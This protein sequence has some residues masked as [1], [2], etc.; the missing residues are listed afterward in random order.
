[1]NLKFG[2]VM[3]SF[4]SLLKKHSLFFVLVSAGVLSAVLSC[5][6]DG[7]WDLLAEQILIA[8]ELENWNRRIKI[9]IDNSAQSDTLTDFPVLVKLNSSNIS[10]SDFKS[11]GSDLS[12]YSSALD[13]RLDYETDT[14]DISGDS[15]IWVR[16][17]SI[18][19]GSA[20]GYFWM[21]YSSDVNTGTQSPESVWSDDYRGVWHLDESGTSYYDSS[22]NGNTGTGGTF[23]QTD[24][25]VQ[26][27]AV[28]LAQN[29]SLTTDSIAIPADPS[30]NDLG[31][32]TYSFW[33]YNSGNT[34]DR[35]LSKDKF[36]FWVSSSTYIRVE[37]SYSDGTMQREFNVMPEGSWT[38][39]AITWD[40]T[41]DGSKILVYS[42]GASVSPGS[43]GNTSGT[44]SSDA[45]SDLFI[46]NDTFFSA[47]NGKNCILDEFR[48]SGKV[49][50]A[51]WIAAQ[52]LSQSGSFLSYGASETVSH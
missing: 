24:P 29:L 37:I 7:A 26:A 4:F 12:F 34:G 50:S 32:V 21:Y 10:Y 46:G 11:E 28:G 36:E 41:L 33:V 5:T 43:S 6:A 8:D 31:P 22:P 39:A 52:Y 3:R 27:G 51:D 49:R 47:S 18:E 44:R 38:Y 14:W 42:N 2:D 45:A 20:G 35:L 23:G 17:P 16:I 25:G 48:I 30:I 40:G 9:S 15:Y 1:M 19:G 13:E